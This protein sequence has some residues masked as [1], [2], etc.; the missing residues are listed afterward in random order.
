MSVWRPAGEE[1]FEQADFNIL[2]RLARLASIAIANASLYKETA[3]AA[4]RAERESQSLRLLNQMGQQMSLADTTEEIFQ[5]ATEFTPQ[6]VPADRVSV[7]LLTEDGEKLQVYA[8]HGRAGLLPTGVQ[9]PLEGTLVGTAVHT[10]QV[11]NC[12]D[13]RQ[14]SELDAQQLTQQGLRSTIVAPMI[15]ADRAI[16]TINIGHRHADVWTPRDESLLLQIASF[17]ATN[18][19]NTRLFVEAEG[20]RAEAVAANEAKSAFLATMSHEIRTPMNA[21]IGM[22]SLLLDTAQNYEQ[23]E[24]TDTFRNSSE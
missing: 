19:E 10:K 5:V 12:P 18:L 6:I 1:N 17:L 24:F 23:L 16:G 2:V 13:L 4:D 22:T 3:A 20:A 11:L 7:A 14:C 21:I 15:V 9:L 8:L